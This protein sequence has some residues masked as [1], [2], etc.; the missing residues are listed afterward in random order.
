MAER[1]DIPRRSVR[2]TGRRRSSVNAG[3]EMWSGTGQPAMSNALVWSATV[4]M[5]IAIIVLVMLLKSG[6]SSGKISE[7]R[8]PA[9]LGVG[10]MQLINTQFPVGIGNGQM[11]LINQNAPYLGL[12]L[13]AL[14]PD[15]A[16]RLG[17]KVGQGVYVNAVVPASPGQKAGVVV[18]DILMRLE[19]TDLAK[20]E[21]V[22]MVLSTKM[23]GEVIKA[24]ILHAGAK[25]SVHIALTNVPLG[26]EAGKMPDVPWV[27]MDVQD[28][29][30]IMRIQFNLPDNKGVL[31]SYVAPGSPAAAVGLRTGDML[32]RVDATR[33]PNVAQF[34]SVI[35]KAKTG[36]RLRLSVMRAG[37]P[38]EMDVIVGR[39]PVAAPT[40]P[41]LPPADIVVE[42]SWIGMDVAEV[43]LKDIASLGLPTG[44]K[45]ILA[46]DVEG[47]P[48]TI[49][50][51]QSG[52]VI[53]AVN[54]AATPDVQS[55]LNATR[56]Q[57]GA[58]V[59]IIRG[60]SHLFISVPPP[61]YTQQG[62]KMNTG[63]DNKFRQVAATTPVIVAALTDENA[64]NSRIGGENNAQA[65]V[66]I[67]L[68][69]RD[70]TV[71]ELKQ[72]TPLASLMQQRG[73]SVLLCTEVAP[74]T[75]TALKAKGISVYSGMTGKIIDGVTL[76][77]QQ[78]LVPAGAR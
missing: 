57:T 15:L 33:I 8:F 25:Q 76:Y 30:A 31:I 49:V 6:G 27:G 13:S 75:L 24:V 46:I 42:A 37:T 11:Q 77:E 71:V 66:F 54:G 23:A 78:G 52:D 50:G 72:S 19:T 41:F 61:G 51:F 47:P 17:V 73:A 70:T 62:S 29:D 12:S 59:E 65:V 16:A 64:V 48:A 20:P 5:V 34:Q 56:Q 53:V 43:K 44:T 55:F 1:L 58:A 26:I 28:V 2:N 74:G 36:Q 45:G 39:K 4:A 69:Q 9:G 14:S 63:L 3:S 67:D 35:V 32:R 21:D 68:R 38:L 22:G 40:V 60:S 7:E 18:G 10:Q